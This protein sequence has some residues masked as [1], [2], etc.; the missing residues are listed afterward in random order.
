MAGIPTT[1]FAERQGAAII[2]H[3]VV[4]RYL[5]YFTNKTGSRSPGGRVAYVD[6]YAGPGVYDDGNPGSPELAAK[7]FDLVD[8]IRDL[9]CFFVE[10]DPEQC[11]TLVEHISPRM[12]SAVIRCGSMEDHVD[13]ILDLYAGLP[14]LAFI[15]PFGLGISDEALTRL[16]TRKE[17]TDLIVNVSLSAV[18]RHA[19]HL[20]SQ[21]QY[22]AK[23][24]FIDNLD[25]ALGGD[26]WQEI[27]L[28]EAEDAADII[29]QEYCSRLSSLRGAT[30]WERVRDRWEGPTAFYLL[31]IT[32]HIDGLWGFN[33]FMSLAHEE[34]RDADP[35]ALTDAELLLPY[36]PQWIDSIKNNVRGLLVGEPN[37]FVI[38]ESMDGVYGDTLGFAREKHVR[39]ALRELHDEGASS[40]NPKGVKDLKRLRVKP[41]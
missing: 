36:G 34:L 18:R 9:E 1:F 28:G 19:G 29:C 35:T 33:E 25:V 38:S 10:R 17:P 40:T 11:A 16:A 15:D 20:T 5:R 7:V 4:G 26:W 30:I 6:G 2:K 22:P 39:A 24:T 32:G 3:G 8:G 21:K 12:P 27:W 23:Q 31:L 41:T 13:E 14:M 37:G